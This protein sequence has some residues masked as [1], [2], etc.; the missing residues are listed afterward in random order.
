MDPSHTSAYSGIR[1]VPPSNPNIAR[2]ALLVDNNAGIARLS[3]YRNNQTTYDTVC[4]NSKLS[5]PNDLA[6]TSKGGIFISQQIYNEKTVVGDGGV[7]YCHQNDTNASAVQ[8]WVGGRTNGI[9]I[10]P[11][12]RTLYVSEAFNC[13]N[14]T[15]CSNVVWRFDIVPGIPYPTLANKTLFVDFAKL[16]NTASVDI[17]GSR[18]DI[19]G[20]LYVSRNGGGGVYKFN[21]AG[22]PLLYIET[23]TKNPAN[24]EFGG[25]DGKT[26]FIVGYCVGVSDKGCVDKL[27]VSVAGKAWTRLHG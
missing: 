12:D 11:D 23:N 24:L 20:N 2:Q 7:W 6:L 15:P 21:P 1:W 4:T 18:T 14:Y 8:L 17:D 3:I 26:M 22:K 5:K 27:Q 19:D 10:S 13:A 9:E 25:S 16:D